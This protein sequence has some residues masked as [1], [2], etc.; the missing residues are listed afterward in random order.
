MHEDTLIQ[1]L[2]RASFLARPVLTP[3]L[4]SPLLLL[5][6]SQVEFCSREVFGLYC[7][8]IM[9][10][11]NLHI[12]SNGIGAGMF[13]KAFVKVSMGTMVLV[14]SCWRC[15]RKTNSFASSVQNVFI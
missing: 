7:L 6:V 12:V 13:H 8:E 11:D 10:L 3:I 9:R 15:A 5:C 2:R 4:P 14:C 1:I